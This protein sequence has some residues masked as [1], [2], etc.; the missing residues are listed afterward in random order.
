M[1]DNRKPEEFFSNECLLLLYLFKLSLKFYIAIS[2]GVQLVC[3]HW[4]NTTICESVVTVFLYR[5]FYIT[6][7]CQGM[8]SQ[9]MGG[10]RIVLLEYGFGSEWNE[11]S[12]RII[13]RRSKENVKFLE[14]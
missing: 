1:L 14:L 3:F 13:N 10:D 4:T 5:L 11:Q 8:E 7:Q 9:Q 12:V 6:G 2:S